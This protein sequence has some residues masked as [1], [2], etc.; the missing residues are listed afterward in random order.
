[1]N[2]RTSG[3]STDE[4]TVL[5]P[6][7]PFVM[8]LA[9]AER[10]KGSPLTEEEVLAVRDNSTCVAM[11][12]SQAQKFYASLDSQVAVPRINPERAWDEWQ[13]IRQHLQ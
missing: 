5:V 6:L 8:I 9:G 4:P 1:M 11:T 2:R 10:Q 7:N 13:E 3:P 12:V